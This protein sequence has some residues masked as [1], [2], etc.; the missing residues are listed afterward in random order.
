MPGTTLDTEMSNTRSI[1]TSPAK[2]SMF[3]K[4]K[5]E[6]SLQ[7]DDLSLRHGAGPGLLS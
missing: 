3:N 1:S 4:G 6:Q 2:D 5:P 7:P